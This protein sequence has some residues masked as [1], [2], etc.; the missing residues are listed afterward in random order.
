M[1]QIGERIRIQ[2]VIKGYSQ[3]YM[4][5]KLDISQSA[6]SNME[7]GITEISARRVCQIAE[8]LEI[9]PLALLPKPKYG[10]HIDLLSLRVTFY[11]LQNL[12]KRKFGKKKSLPNND[13]DI[14]SD[15]SK[16]RN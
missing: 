11:R 13:D 3:E 1:E 5:Y 15:I 16:S 14:H 12:W 6:Y 10:T 4:S 9:S 2:R 8:I 7:R